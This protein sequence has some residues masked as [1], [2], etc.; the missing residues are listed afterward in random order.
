MGVQNKIEEIRRQ[1]EYIRLRWAW[2][3]TAICMVFVLMIWIFSMSRQNSQWEIPNLTSEQQSVFDSLGQQGQ[4]LSN[5]A[6]QINN[7]MQNQSQ[8]TNQ[9]SNSNQSAG[10]SSGNT[11]QSLIP[12]QSDSNSNL[13]PDQTDNS[14]S[15]TSS[16]S[17][18]DPSSS[19]LTPDQAPTSATDQATNPDFT[20]QNGSQAQPMS[21]PSAAN[22]NQN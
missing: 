4:S 1:P 15:N 20:D 19:D 22:T 9:G 12:D 14:S 3:L 5:S 13:T 16:S 11:G 2:G 17:L 10:Q 21:Q 6:G 8:N 7:L 18:P